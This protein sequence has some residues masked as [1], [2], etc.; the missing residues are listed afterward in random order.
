MRNK[1]KAKYKFVVLKKRKYFFYK[2]TWEDITADGGHAT[3]FEFLGMKP[4]IMI[5]HGYLFNKDKKYVRTFAS[6]EENDE[7]FSDRNV[8]PR[9]CILKMEKILL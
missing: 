5:T 8:I 2:I 4:S 6:Y 1:K 9:G 3:A 7:L